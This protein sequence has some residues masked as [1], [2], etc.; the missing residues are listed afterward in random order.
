M[1][2]LVIEDEQSA[3]KRLINMLN[4]IDSKAEII[5][6]LESVEE[7]ISWFNNNAAPDLILMD[8][9]L[10]DGSSFEIFNHVSFHSP[11]IFITAYDEYAI[12][13]FKVNSVDYLLKP[14]KREELAEAIA[15][16]KKLHAV[17]DH[18]TLKRISEALL[19]QADISDKPKRLVVKYGE[20]IK[21]IDIS[22]VAYAFAEN[23]NVFIRIKDERD[24]PYDGSLDKL[25]DDLSG[26][27]FY[28]ANR[29]LIVNIESIENMVTV[30]KSRVKLKLIP[31]F[32]HDSIVSTNRSG[33][34]KKWLTGK[35]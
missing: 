18:D 26:K 5:D 7:S 16:Y 12:D 29:G 30:S 14:I 32:E 15:K 2:V 10:A 19:R 35:H 4:E 28:R 21:A 34:F 20:T 1:K 33:D 13:A 11:I 6:T 23:K 17:V 8:I 31:P 22:E 3:A 27:K 9:Q 25:M 24:Y